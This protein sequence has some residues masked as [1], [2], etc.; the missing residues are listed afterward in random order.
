MQS[1]YPAVAWAIPIAAILA[2]LL[3]G[4]V[5]KASEQQPAS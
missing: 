1:R 4:V 3:P 5:E 2:V